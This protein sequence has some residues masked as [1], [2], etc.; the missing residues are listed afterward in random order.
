MKPKNPP[1]FPSAI[2]PGMHGCW[3]MTLRD[4]F[5]AAALPAVIAWHQRRNEYDEVKRDNEANGLPSFSLMPGSADPVIIAED[6]YN[7]AD[8]MLEARTVAAPQPPVEGREPF[9]YVNTHTG[10]FFK[11][12]E[13][14]RKNNQGHWRTVYTAPA[15]ADA[16]PLQ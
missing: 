4:Y 10:Q 11:D 12:V 8:T 7:M 15:P 16:E 9:G 3:G 5:A 6:C 14:S 2:A 1:A 13:P